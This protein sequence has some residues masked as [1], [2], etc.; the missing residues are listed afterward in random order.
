[1][2]AFVSAPIDTLST[3]FRLLRSHA[4]SL[5][6]NSLYSDGVAA[7]ADGF[8]VNSTLEVLE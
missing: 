8:K 6:S 7:L 5:S 1:M 4:R 3:C 2:F